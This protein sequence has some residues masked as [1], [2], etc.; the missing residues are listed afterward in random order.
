MKVIFLDIDGVLNAGLVR[1]DGQEH[2]LDLEAIARLNRLGAATGAAVVLTSS[3]RLLYRWPECRDLLGR[4]GLRLEVIGET[5]DLWTWREDAEAARRREIEDWLARHGV[6][7]D[8]ALFPAEVPR[9][10]RTDEAIGLTDADVERA[11]A[12]LL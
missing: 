2:A 11:I 12:A 4:Y 7:D 9:F 6:L 3:W 8:L 1:Y 5:A 10:V